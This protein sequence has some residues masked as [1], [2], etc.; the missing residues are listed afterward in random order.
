MSVESADD[1]AAFFNPDDFGEAASWTPQG[2]SAASVNCIVNR[3]TEHGYAG[4][5][6]VKNTVTTLRLAD[7]SLPSGA[8]EG[9]A[10]TVRS[11]DFTVRSIEPDGTGVSV[12]RLERV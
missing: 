9:D 6:P 8:D 10:V 11:L 3:E 1:L 5:M 7:A 2:G 4:D 12:V